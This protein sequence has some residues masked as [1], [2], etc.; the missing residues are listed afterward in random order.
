VLSIDVDD[1][2]VVEDRLIIITV[3]LPRVLGA[4]LP[5]PRLQ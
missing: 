1:V 4:E 3:G 5:Y 2:P